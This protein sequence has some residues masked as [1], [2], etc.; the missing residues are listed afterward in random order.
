MTR[1]GHLESDGALNRPHPT[2]PHAQIF[3]E[4][5]NFLLRNWSAS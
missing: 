4:R 2:R 5:L 1:R 3:L